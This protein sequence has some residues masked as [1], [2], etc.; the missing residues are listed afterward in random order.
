MCQAELSIIRAQTLHGLL[1]IDTG[2]CQISIK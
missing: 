2:S 1:F